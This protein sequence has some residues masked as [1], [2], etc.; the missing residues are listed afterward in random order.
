MQQE[1]EQTPITRDAFKKAINFPVENVSYRS[2]KCR[3]QTNRN[4]KQNI[5]HQLEQLMPN[6]YEIRSDVLKM[7]LEFLKWQTELK[8]KIDGDTLKTNTRFSEKYRIPSY[9]KRIYAM[10]IRQSQKNQKVKSI[11]K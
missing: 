1:G 4:F 8:I 10:R 5:N 7:S 11:I 6:A 3:F 2:K 9:Q